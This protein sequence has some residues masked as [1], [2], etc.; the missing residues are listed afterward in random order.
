MIWIT[1]LNQKAIVLNSDLIE[2]IECTPDTLITLTSGQK[3]TALESP[4][5]VI[6]KVRAYKRSVGCAA[7][8]PA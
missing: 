3:I 5:D 4:E 6:E 7:G 2:Q 8:V 1:R